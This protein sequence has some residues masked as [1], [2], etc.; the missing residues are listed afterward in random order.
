HETLSR[1]PGEEVAFDEIVRPLVRMVEE[2]LLS[3]DRDIRVEVDGEAGELPAVVATPLA[4]VL[5]ELIQNTVDHAFPEDRVDGR[6]RVHL[7]NDG[8]VLLVRVADDGVGLPPGFSLDRS[9][10]LGL[11]IVR[12]LATSELGGKIDMYNDGG[13]VV[14]LRVPVTGERSPA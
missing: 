5:T 4:V 14:E 10:G 9:D 6:V 2:G 7:G 12:V 8:Q 3:P 13:A 11:T 1:A